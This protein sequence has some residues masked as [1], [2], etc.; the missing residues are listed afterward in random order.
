MKLTNAGANWPYGG[1]PKRF[2][3]YDLPCEDA[4]T[5]VLRGQC[6]SGK[7]AVQTTRRG[8]R[9]PTKE[10]KV[11]RE[12]WTRQLQGQFQETIAW[13]VVASIDY[14]PSDLRTRD[15][16]GM[17]VAIRKIDELRTAE[18]LR[19]STESCRRILAAV[20]LLP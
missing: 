2:Y 13:P 1:W 9:Y 8:Q 20:R 14:T 7:N 15:I 19:N 5:L 17:M 10:F 12:D 16:P 3:P 4:V 11:W 18:R 6:K